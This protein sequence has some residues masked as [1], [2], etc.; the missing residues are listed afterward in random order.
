M[1]N[2]S[3]HTIAGSCLI[4]SIPSVILSGNLRDGL[5]L[6]L[7]SVMLLMLL[8]PLQMDTEK[9]LAMTCLLSVT[10]AT[11]LN[12]LPSVGLA[13]TPA[14][15]LLVVFNVALLGYIGRGSNS[16]PAL[17]RVKQSLLTGVF[18]LTALVLLLGLRTIFGYGFGAGRDAPPLPTWQLALLLYPGGVILVAGLLY[19]LLREREMEAEL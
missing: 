15:T 6:G 18:F 19:L 16:T 4:L 17:S 9:G 7:V 12:V 11:L 2:R 14:P 1:N 8:S 10:V 3:L 5:I 13:G